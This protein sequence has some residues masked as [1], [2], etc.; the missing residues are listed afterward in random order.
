MR[1]AL[2]SLLRARKLDVTLT[3][4]PGSL[5]PP[6]ERLA[7]I[8]GCPDLDAALGGGLRRGHLS[9]ITGPMSSGVTRVAVAAMTAAAA[10]GEAVALVDA[11]DTFD[12]AFAAARG[13]D[14]SRL[15]WVRLSTGLEAGPSTGLGA[16]ADAAARALKAFSLILQA[17]GFGLVVLDLADVPAAALRRFPWYWT[18]STWMRIARIVEGSDTVALLVGSEHVARSSGGATIALGPSTVRWQGEAHRARVFSGLVPEPRVIGG[19]R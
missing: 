4:T 18:S 14:L 3:G 2:E 10:R 7:P 6:P 5:P 12:P 9:E 13:L 19:R 1:A 8:P 15:L 16:R 17:G 11:C